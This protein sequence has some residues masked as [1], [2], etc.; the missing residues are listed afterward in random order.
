MYEI[1]DVPELQRGDQ[2]QRDYTKQTHLDDSER[3]P[4]DSP[5]QYYSRGAGHHIEVMHRTCLSRVFGSHWTELT[6]A[7]MQGKTQGL[8]LHPSKKGLTLLFT[9]PV[10]YY[11]SFM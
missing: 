2:P 10:K 4:L 5:A 6:A 3:P 11:R 1:M 8:F 9:L 7:A